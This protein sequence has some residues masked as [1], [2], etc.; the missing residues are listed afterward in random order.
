MAKNTTISKETLLNQ[1]MVS[2]NLFAAAIHI[3]QTDGTIKHS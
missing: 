1:L 3:T 2:K